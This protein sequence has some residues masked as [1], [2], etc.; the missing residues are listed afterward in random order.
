MTEIVRL[1][2]FHTCSV[3][4]LLPDIILLKLKYVPLFIHSLN[5]NPS[6]FNNV[7]ITGKE[8]GPIP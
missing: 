6:S 7:L 8:A 5:D 2:L 1:K 4:F 3:H